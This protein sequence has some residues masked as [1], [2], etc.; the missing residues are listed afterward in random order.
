[1]MMMMM[2]M[3]MMVVVMVMVM[4]MVMVV[5]MMVSDRLLR[6][7]FAHGIRD[8]SNLT[9]MQPILKSLHSTQSDQFFAPLLCSSASWNCRFR[10]RPW[11][12]ILPSPLEIRCLLPRWRPIKLLLKCVASIFPCAKHCSQLRATEMGTL[13]IVATRSC[14]AT[15][16]AL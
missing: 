6:M 14:V 16:A 2:M 9:P 8:T 1:M 3:M 5:V 12:A 13:R 4:V 11:V 10:T 7:T 15:S